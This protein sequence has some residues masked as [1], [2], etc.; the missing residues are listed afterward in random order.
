MTEVTDLPDSSELEN[1]I[2]ATAL[3]GVDSVRE[4]I[5]IIEG[6]LQGVLDRELVSTSEVADLLLDLRSILARAES[7]LVAG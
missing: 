7:Q 1:L 2:G 5:Q 6:G 4:A 3:A